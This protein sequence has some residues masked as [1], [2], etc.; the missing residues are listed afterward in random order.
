MDA[1]TTT[2]D[3]DLLKV[4]NRFLQTVVVVDDRAF[5]EVAPQVLLPDED[6]DPA[7]GGRGVS[8]DLGEPP[9]PTSMILMPRRSPMRLHE[10]G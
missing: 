1:Q 10:M 8:D 2:Y 6:S 9:T 3:E 5:K 7:P 4:V